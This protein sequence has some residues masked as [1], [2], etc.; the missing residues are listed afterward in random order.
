MRRGVE[1]TI[2]V[3]AQYGLT[4]EEVEKMLLDF[5]THANEDMQARS[6]VDARTEVGQLIGTTNNF[7]IKN[8]SFLKEEEI[9]TTIKAITS[10]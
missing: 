10:L 3:K 5:V 7:L 1:Q 4:N 2:D 8:K 6:L 9:T